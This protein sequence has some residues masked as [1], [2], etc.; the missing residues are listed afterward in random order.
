M[1]SYLRPFGVRGQRTWMRP[2][3][4]KREIGVHEKHRMASVFVSSQGNQKCRTS[5]SLL[6]PR[7]GEAGRRGAHERATVGG[8]GKA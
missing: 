8:G 2:N 1:T 4:R 5:V 7:P 3:G 6:E